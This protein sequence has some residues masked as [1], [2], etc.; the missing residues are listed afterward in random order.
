[1][2]SCSKY[3]YIKPSLKKASKEAPEVIKEEDW[4]VHS[5]DLSDEFDSDEEVK[6]VAKGN[7]Q[8]K[9]DTYPFKNIILS[10]S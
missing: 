2:N 5:D 4:E 7:A 1:M 6:Q 8:G 3:A 10:L 9:T